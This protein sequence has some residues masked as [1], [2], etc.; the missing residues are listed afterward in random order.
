DAH[1]G[2]E[3]RSLPGHKGKIYSVAFVSRGIL[4]ASV[5]EDRTLRFWDVASGRQR[6]ATPL[7]Q[8]LLTVL[9]PDGTAFALRVA[10]NTVAVFDATTG[11]EAVKLAGGGAVPGY[12]GE[13]CFSAGGRLFAPSEGGGVAGWD[14]ATGAAVC[15][16]TATG[17]D[18]FALAPD[19]KT[20]AVADRQVIG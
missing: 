17:A 13:L 10:P 6:S 2:K 15:R 7:K 1:S 9:A 14:T 5:S 18:A 3:L 4:L 16:V 19:G 8:P 20:A 12:V 11:A